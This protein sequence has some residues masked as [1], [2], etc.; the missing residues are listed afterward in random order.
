MTRSLPPGLG[1]SRL[2]LALDEEVVDHDV[3]L[4]HL[5]AGHALDA[6]D[7]VAAH[8]LCPLDDALTVVGH[9]VQ[10]DGRLP[11]AHLHADALSGLVHTLLSRHLRAQ[12]SHRPSEPFA[13]LMDARDLSSRQGRDLGDY[14][15]RNPRV[16]PL[17]F[18]RSVA[19][20]SGG[21]ARPR[22]A[23]AARAGIGRRP[24]RGSGS[25]LGSRLL[26]SHDFSLLGAIYGWK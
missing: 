6:I 10:V 5:E 17:S 23:G 20:P 1:R 18:E 22:T 3:D 7:H 21:H 11:L 25:N 2:R 12:A 15:I 8:G 14:A 13:H 9:E 4:G 24:A 26:L 16:P 19:S